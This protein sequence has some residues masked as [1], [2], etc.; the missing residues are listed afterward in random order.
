MTEI[1][2]M[3]DCNFYVRLNKLRLTISSKVR[4]LLSCCVIFDL[5]PL[6]LPFDLVFTHIERT[7]RFENAIFKQRQ[8]INSRMTEM[9]GLLKELTTTRT[10]KKVLIR[11][12]EKFTVTKNVNSISL[13]KGEEEG[14][15]KTKITLDNTENPIEIETETPVKEAETKNEAENEAKN[16]SIK[17]PENEEAVEAPGSHPVVYT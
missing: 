7:R 14:S 3:N 1:P 13:T 10:P 17:T 15:N 4:L 8:E 16:K 5:E 6:L 12:E 2:S 9:F 11:E